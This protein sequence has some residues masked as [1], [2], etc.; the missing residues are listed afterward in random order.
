[1]RGVRSAGANEGDGVRLRLPP[2]ERAS[3]GARDA[4]WKGDGGG[5]TERSLGRGVDARG[6]TGGSPSPSGRGPSGTPGDDHLS[7]N[8]SRTRAT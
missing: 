6:D 7:G 8:S 1:M 3:E 2:V 5:G 4:R